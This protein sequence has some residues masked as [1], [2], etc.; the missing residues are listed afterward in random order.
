MLH[1]RTLVGA[2]TTLRGGA[3]IGG[4]ERAAI[5]LAVVADWKEGLALT[6]ALKGLG[7]YPELRSGDNPAVAERFIIGT[8]TSW[9]WAIGCAVGQRSLI[10]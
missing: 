9:L 3:W 7:R 8:F 5:Y 6:L 4:L 10:G 1:E 2:R